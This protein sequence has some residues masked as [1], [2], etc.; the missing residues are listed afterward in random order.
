MPRLA[1]PT[2]I[3]LLCLLAL[4]AAD[5]KKKKGHGVP[6]PDGFPPVLEEELAVTSVP[7][8]GSAPAIVL[9]EA[10][11]NQ[12]EGFSFVRVHY[13]RRVKITGQEGVERYGDFVYQLY[14]DWRV[15]AVEARTVLPGGEEIDAGEGVFHERSTD[16]YHTIRVAWP[17]VRVGAILDLHIS[18]SADA[19]VI[20]PWV[21]QGD[22]PVLCSKFVI[23]P[24]PGL[25]YRAAAFNMPDER[26][27]PESFNVG[28]GRAHVWSFENLAP[29]PDE[30]NQPARTDVSQTLIVIPQEFRDQ[31]SGTGLALARDWKSWSYWGRE[32]FESWVERGAGDVSKLA[33]DVAGGLATPEEKAEAIRV[34]LRERV[35]ADYLGTGR[36]HDSPDE[37]LADGAGTTGEVAAAALAMLQAVGVDGELMA[38]RLRTSGALPRE[39]PIPSLFDDLI[40]RFRSGAKESYFCPSADLPAG[41][42]PWNRRGVLALPYDGKAEAPVEIADFSAAENRRMREVSARIDAE[43]RLAGESTFRCSGISAERWRNR[44]RDLEPDERKDEVEERLQ[45]WMPGLVLG[46]LEIENLDHGTEELKIVSRWEVPGYGTRAG[47]RLLVNLHLFDRVATDDWAADERS[48]LIDLGERYA[49]R[50]VVTLELP[51]GALRVDLPDKAIYNAGPVGIYKAVY[52]QQGNQLTAER[53]MRLDRYWFPVESYAGLRRWFTDIAAADDDA[54]AIE[55]Q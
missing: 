55:M 54:V 1:R 37:M 13:Y 36:Y 34:A 30:P 52:R 4:S 26:V 5:A 15:R 19:V 51:P 53:Q 27:K 18:M 7:G 29:L 47:K 20:P 49:A 6:L 35:Q 32:N 8:A 10:L 12:W 46:E 16:S 41:T 17:Q 14:G 48:T 43:G 39:F 40:V 50:D 24:P 23:I 25:K 31:L 38:L 42:L 2:T 11:Q 44:L 9:L 3:L 21:L 33:R 45:R 22:L 28:Q